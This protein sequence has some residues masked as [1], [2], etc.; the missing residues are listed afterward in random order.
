M[1]SSVNNSIPI[2]QMLSWINL[3]KTIS[4]LWKLTKSK[5]VKKHLFKNYAEISEE[6]QECM[7]S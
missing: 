2:K 5:Q 6:H 1:K 4:E 7:A 3:F